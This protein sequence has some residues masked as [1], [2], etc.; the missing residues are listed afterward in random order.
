MKEVRINYWNVAT[1]A[2][3]W[4][5]RKT[6]YANWP[7][8]IYF[9]MVPEAWAALKALGISPVVH[10]NP[11]HRKTCRQCDGEFFS[12]GKHTKYCTDACATKAR[13]ESKIESRSWERKH[14]RAGRTCMVC[15]EPFDAQRFSKRFCSGKCRVAAHR[16]RHSAAG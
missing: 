2:P 7:A 16:R 9:E 10:F 6:S 13:N 4:A 5:C 15:G 14:A 12:K 11:E 1:S 3:A 8:R